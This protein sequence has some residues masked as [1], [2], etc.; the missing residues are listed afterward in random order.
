MCLVL[1]HYTYSRNMVYYSY[2]IHIV[3]TNSAKKNKHTYVCMYV[4]IYIYIYKYI[5]I[6]LQF[7]L[8]CE[9]NSWQH[10]NAALNFYSPQ[11][12]SHPFNCHQDKEE[13]FM[14]HSVPSS[15]CALFTPLQHSICYSNAMKQT[16]STDVS[17][18]QDH[19]ILCQKCSY[20][21]VI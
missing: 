15:L 10:P 6:P 8:L 19:V 14:C 21:E 1:Y 18:F 7:A 5:Y 17:M 13:S 3:W 12:C 16:A 2:K 9:P 11:L 20:T 4:Y